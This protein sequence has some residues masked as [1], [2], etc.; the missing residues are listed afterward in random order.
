MNNTTSEK[1]PVSQKTP[2]GIL[3]D[4]VLQCKKYD[5]QS[6]KVLLEKGDP[7]ISKQMLIERAK[8]VAVLPQLIQESVNNG[9]VFPEDEMYNL[10]ALATL[11]NEAIE[12]KN[13]FGLGTLLTQKGIKH[14]EPNH[15]EKLVNKIYPEKIEEVKE[16]I[17]GFAG[18]LKI[19]TSNDEFIE[20]LD[21]YLTP[22]DVEILGG[23]DVAALKLSECYPFLGIFAAFP[24]TFDRNAFMATAG[25]GMTKVEGERAFEIGLRNG[26]L[27][28]EPEVGPGRVSLSE[29]M[30]E[31]LGQFL[32]DD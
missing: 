6:Q 22:E 20:L 28:S 25:S 8:L 29:S 1:G 32:T 3:R 19:G 15:L 10:R 9:N 14:N 23:R 2:E 17:D 12:T 4:T 27:Q 31:K 11:A 16:K 13:D 5:D 30:L 21:K 26:I 18:E 7:N 24:G